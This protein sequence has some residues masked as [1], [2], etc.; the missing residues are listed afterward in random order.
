MHR[1]L[2]RAAA[3]AFAALAVTA[4]AFA[5]YP[6]LSTDLVGPAVNGVVPSGAAKVD[7]SKLPAVPGTLW[8]EVKNVNLPD[9]TVLWVV[10]DGDPVGVI[11]LARGQGRLATPI[12]MQVGRGSS[13]IFVGLGDV[14]ILTNPGAWKT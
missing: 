12:P 8:V 10:L 11:P 6:K 13:Q 2:C 4:P 14:V 1:P 7:Q 3:V 5:I 9:G